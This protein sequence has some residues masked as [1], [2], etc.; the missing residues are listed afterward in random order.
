MAPPVTM[1]PNPE[2]AKGFQLLEFTIAPPTTRKIRMALILINTMTLLASADS[3]IPRTSST[4]RMK[5]IRN[6]GTLKYAPVQCPDS[7]TGVDHR[8]GKFKPNDDN[9]AL[10]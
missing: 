9:C 5:M 6:A 3:L 7:H 2:G 4:V 1:P 8:S 10:V